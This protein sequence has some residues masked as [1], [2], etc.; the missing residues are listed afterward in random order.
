MPLDML[1]GVM[2]TVLELI[3]ATEATP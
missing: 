2:R 1:A 3:A